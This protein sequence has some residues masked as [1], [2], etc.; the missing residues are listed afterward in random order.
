MTSFNNWKIPMISFTKRKIKIIYFITHLAFI[1]LHSN[2]AW[3]PAYKNLF[4]V[5]MESNPL[6]SLMIKVF[7]GFFK[8]FQWY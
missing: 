1:S 7:S 4:R 3:D 2:G 6:S 5:D 8:N